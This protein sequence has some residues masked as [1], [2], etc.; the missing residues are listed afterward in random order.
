MA[1]ATR[2]RRASTCLRSRTLRPY[3]N[4]L[5]AVLSQHAREGGTLCRLLSLTATLGR[6]GARTSRR[7][8]RMS[9]GEGVSIDHMAIG[10]TRLDAPHWLEPRET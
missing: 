8:A 2:I 9:M 3:H 6:A 5:L 1:G 10:S 4:L 7:G